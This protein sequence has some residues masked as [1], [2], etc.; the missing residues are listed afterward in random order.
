MTVRKNVAPS[1]FRTEAIAARG[2]DA[3]QR[4]A[5][6]YARCEQTTGVRRERQGAVLRSQDDGRA[7][8]YSPDCPE[9]ATHCGGEHHE[10]YY[11]HCPLTLPKTK[12]SD[13]TSVTLSGTHKSHGRFGNE[14]ITVGL[15]HRYSPSLSFKVCTLVLSMSVLD[16][17]SMCARPSPRHPL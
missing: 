10:K 9:A 8:L 15:T 4:L 16:L 5:F 6:Y 1:P 13:Q 7:F 17:R 12:L 2:A 11:Q 3:F 14:K